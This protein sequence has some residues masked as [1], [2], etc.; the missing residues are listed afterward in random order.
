MPVG[1]DSPGF[2]AALDV[3][4]TQTISPVEQTANQPPSTNP[5]LQPARDSPRPWVR[6]MRVVPP[7]VG[8]CGRQKLPGQRG[9]I[10]WRASFGRSECQTSADNLFPTR[11]SF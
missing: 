10:L 4:S 5:S 2:F 11:A 9:C 7:D 8:I 6:T 3:A 1:P